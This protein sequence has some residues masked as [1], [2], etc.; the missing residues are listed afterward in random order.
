MLKQSQFSFGTNQGPNGKLC[1]TEYM[2]NGSKNHSGS[3]KGNVDNKV[4]K[5]YADTSLGKKCYYSIIKEYFRKLPKDAPNGVFLF[6]QD[7]QEPQ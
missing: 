5:Q 2:E 6:S 4:V 1:Y 7:T 3:Y